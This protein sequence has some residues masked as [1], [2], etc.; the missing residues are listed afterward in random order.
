MSF[1]PD[2]PATIA[3]TL[4]TSIN[5]ELNLPCS[6][7]VAA[8]KLVAKIANNVGKASAAFAAERDHGRPTRAGSGVSQPAADRRSVGRRAEDG[9]GAGASW[10]EDNWRR[11]RVAAGAVEPPVRQER[12]AIARHARGIDDRPVGRSA[13]RSRSAKR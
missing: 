10:R 2:D 3:R 5:E 12:Q 9:R 1:L 13:R 7:G 4:Q 6:I 11:H 8:N